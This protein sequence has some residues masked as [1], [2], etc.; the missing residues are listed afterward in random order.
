MHQGEDDVL[1]F[2][3]YTP[4]KEEERGEMSPIGAGAHSDYGTMTLLFQGACSPMQTKPL[5]SR[6]AALVRS[7][8]LVIWE[9]FVGWW[10]MVDSVGGLQVKSQDQWIDAQVIPGTILYVIPLRTLVFDSASP[11]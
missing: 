7:P 8:A 5:L 2:L 9:L 10:L 11:L 4:S 6:L 3:L 1:R